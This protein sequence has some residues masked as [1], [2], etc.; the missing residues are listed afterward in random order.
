MVNPLYET[1][2]YAWTLEQ[3]T[4]LK[5]GNFPC[6]DISNLA[7]EIE[8][9][10]KQ[11]RQELK[12][13][14]GILIGHLLKWH[15]Q[16]KNRSKSWRVMIRNQRREIIDLL[17]ENPRLKSYL[18][19]AIHKGYQTGLDLAVL[20]TPL[21]YPDLPGNSIYTITQLL[22]PDFPDDLHPQ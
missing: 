4:L 13:R 22:D 20:E 15:Y 16:P 1:D 5:Q 2:F 9:L 11:Q 7:V 3:S 21:D 17:A 14:L 6:L 18:P 8:S 19:T 12:S 10:G